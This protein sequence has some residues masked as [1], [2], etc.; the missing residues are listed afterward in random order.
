MM[1]HIKRLRKE[2]RQHKYLGAAEIKAL[3]FDF[4]VHDLYLSFNKLALY[5]DELK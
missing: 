3:R 4:E 5:R 2:L 1:N